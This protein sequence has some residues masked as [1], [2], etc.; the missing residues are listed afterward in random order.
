MNGGFIS[1]LALNTLRYIGE[2]GGGKILEMF[3]KREVGK[4]RKQNPK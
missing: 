3:E 4:K 2:R 1:V